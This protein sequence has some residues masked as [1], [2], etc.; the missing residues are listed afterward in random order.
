M[1]FRSTRASSGEVTFREAV[2]TGLA[3]DGGL[4]QPTAWPDLSDL[5]R[6]FG[7]QTDFRTVAARTVGR[8]LDGELSEEA[9]GRIVE[10][11]FP[12]SPRLQAVDE[13]ITLL[14]LF[15]GPTCAFKDFGASFLACA[16][17]ELLR[18]EERRAV[19]LVATSGDTGSAVA[20]AFHG[21]ESLSVVVLY[22]SGR[23]SPLQEKQLTTLGGNVAAL[24]VLGCFDDCQRLVKQAFQDAG[25]RRALGLTS[26]NSI[27]LGRLIPQSFYYI[28]AWARLGGRGA[29]ERVAFCVPSGNFGN[30][31][32][33]VYA[34]KWGLP[35][36]SF[37]AATNRND[38]VPRYLQTGRFVPQD[39]IQ[40]LSNAMDV[41]DPSNFER[42]QAIFAAEAGPM[43]SL[44]H[45]ASV[46]D[47]DTLEAIREVHETYGLLLDPH[48]AVGYRAARR[49][50]GGVRPSHASA[51]RPRV[52]ASAFRAERGAPAPPAGRPVVVLATA[53]PAKFN[54]IVRQATGVEPPMPE[55][56][57]AV[58]DRPKQATLLENSYP[59]LA[60]FLRGR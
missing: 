34:W 29:E 48:T 44:I 7:P 3:P 10:C 51:S 35:V 55:S 17:D 59:A 14:E 41:G 23:V 19:I 58:L 57:R 18:Q 47:P 2:F 60:E 6:S 39:S 8:L 32:A 46:S 11:A 12:F 33:G 53:H 24:E 9:I 49:W 26:A 38:V 37:L 5:F 30:L 36:G 54:E 31:T 1:R 15:H 56:L 21:R 43:Q 40:T 13:E 50:L 52:G 27:N 25:L 20:R 45:G 4:F 16:M 42:L 22:P 28:D